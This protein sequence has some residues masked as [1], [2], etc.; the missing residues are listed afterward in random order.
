L[1]NCVSQIHE[2]FNLEEQNLTN[3]SNHVT[4]YYNLLSDTLDYIKKFTKDGIKKQQQSSTQKVLPNSLPENRQ[5]QT[6]TK[7]ENS[8]PVELQFRRKLEMLTKHIKLFDL[9]IDF[10]LQQFEECDAKDHKDLEVKRVEISP[11]PKLE[12]TIVDTIHSQKGAARVPQKRLSNG[13]LN[14]V[15]TQWNSVKGGQQSSTIKKL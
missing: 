14:P 2:K 15:Q 1:I 11:L 9:Q 7:K 6:Y 13:S 5:S 4:E 8:L 3:Y 12:R 10:N